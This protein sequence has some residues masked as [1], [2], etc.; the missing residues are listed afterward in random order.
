MT[1]TDFI[2]IYEELN[3]LTE[4]S[5]FHQ[6]QDYLDNDGKPLT[7]EDVLNMPD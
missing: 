6:A 7:V 2:K 1:K 5:R 4:G 3:I